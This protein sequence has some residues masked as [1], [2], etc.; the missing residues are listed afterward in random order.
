MHTINFLQDSWSALKPGTLP[1]VRQFVIIHTIMTLIVMLYGMVIGFVIWKGSPRGR[2]LA[3]QYL[4][5]RI[6]L[7][8]VIGA[9]PL[10]WAYREFG[11]R[12]ARSM[13]SKMA[14]GS[15]LEITICLLWLGYF[16]YSRRVREVY[17]M[18]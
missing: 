2:R 18:A 12:A 8:L 5:V 16:V 11:A 15:L 7:V 4:I 6:L 14:P 3:Q 10:Q 17:S 9:I 13:I 1:V